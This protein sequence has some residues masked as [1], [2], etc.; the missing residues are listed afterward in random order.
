MQ[1]GPPIASFASAG[2]ETLLGNILDPNREVAPLYQAYTY[3][4]TDGTTATG[5]ILTENSSEITLRM[6]GGI[7]KTFPRHQVGSMK[8]LGQ[9]LMPEGLEATVTVEEMADLLAYLLTPPKG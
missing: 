2:A 6:P 5:F 1:L 9:S 3:E 7:D 4:L 8:G